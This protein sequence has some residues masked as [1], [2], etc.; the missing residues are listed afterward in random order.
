MDT[1]LK[2]KNT[3][4]TGS[5][6]KEIIHLS[7]VLMIICAAV[8]LVLSFVNEITKDRI[9]LNEEAEKK[10]AITA[11]FGGG[12]VEYTPLDI[13]NDNVS[14]IY[15]VKN[16]TGRLGYAVSVSPSGFGGNIDMIV[17]IGTDEKIIGIRIVSLSETPGLG[18]RVRDDDFLS[19]FI[20]KT[21]SVEL[22]HGVDAISGSTI[23]SK[24]VTH[25]V[26]SALSAL[27]EYLTGGV[28]TV[29]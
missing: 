12:D 10:Q 3:R 24:A 8:A 4:S 9:V 25:G 21:G 13:E 11:L 18:T 22:G 2:S 15:D 14:A 17:G 20:G 27:N 28:V 6:V 16:S 19:A 26:N 7:L 1:S 5:G 23:S 29:Q